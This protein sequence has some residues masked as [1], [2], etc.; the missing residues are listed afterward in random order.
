MWRRHANELLMRFQVSSTSLHGSRND[1]DERHSRC[2]VCCPGEWVWVDSNGK[3]GK[4]TFCR[5]A[6]WSWVSAICN[7][8]GD[9]AA[10]SRK[11]LK[12]FAQNLL[13]WKRALCSEWI[14]RVTDPRVMCKFREIW[15]IGSQ[16]N[17]ASLTRQKKTKFWLA[18]SLSLLRGSRPKCA[19]Q[20]MYSEC[21]KFHPNSFT[22]G[23]I[24]AERVN[25]VETRDEV[26]PILGEAIA[27]RRVI[28][29]RDRSFTKAP[30]RPVTGQ[31]GIW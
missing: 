15:P 8:F 23:G 29:L 27:S 3:S 26:N 18:L 24:I 20:T 22:F 30:L 10:W 11:S 9:I 6:N 1:V 19:R 28:I 2:A 21:P 31:L 13:F 12:I 16:W 14:H 7:H 25:T 5:L 17:R 4:S